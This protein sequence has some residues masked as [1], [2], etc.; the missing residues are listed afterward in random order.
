MHT[1]APKPKAPQQ[2][3]SAESTVSGR[4]HLRHSPDARSTL[5]SQR[6]IEN[7]ATRRALQADAEAPGAE[8]TGTA[9]HRLGHN[10]GEIPVHAPTAKAIQTKPVIDGP[11]D[12][13]EQEADRVSEQI[14]RTPEPRVQRKCARG[15]A[16]GSEGECEACGKKHQS[17]Q[18]VSVD[19]AGPVAGGFAPPVV[20]DVLRSPAR[21]LAPQTRALMEAHFGHDF[22]Q[23]RI[24]AD[25]GASHAADAVQAQ[26]FTYGSDIVFGSG[27]FAPS[28]QAGLRLLAHELTHV[29]QQGAAPPKAATRS[30]AE[31]A[32]EGATGA[33]APRPT[34]VSEPG[35]LQRRPKDGKDSPERETC[36]PVERGER[37]EAAG[38]QLRLVERIPREEWLIYGFPI[39][40]SEISVAEAGR[41]ISEIA[42]TLQQNHLIYMTSWDPLEVLGFSDCLAG[43]KVDNHAIR[44]LRAAKFCAGVKDYYD[45]GNADLIQPSGPSPLIQSC[46]PAPMAQYVGPNATRVERAQ[47][48]SILIRRVAPAKVQV[49]AAEKVE[50]VE[51]DESYPY[52]PK[53]GPS[54]DNCSIYRGAQ[55]RKLLGEGYT[56]NAHCSCMVTPD[57]P[58][59]NCVRKCLQEKM[60]ALLISEYAGRMPDDP[61]MDIHTAC[62]IIW[63][64][65]R[66]CY[67][68]CGCASEFIDYLP[69]RLVCDKSLP[70]AVDSAAIN[71]TNRCMPA[72]KGDKYLPV[73]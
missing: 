55:S 16:H 66:E 5:H 46:G 22:S 50:F 44:Q 58:H 29:V 20:D 64:D 13:S 62:P 72:T 35:R 6:A 48:R 59:N 73:D 27:K 63:R 40:G 18:R 33:E 25:T 56:K 43:P 37:E 68:D 7:Q 9:T 23:V 17:L 24:H 2:T 67:H 14:V 61:L 41:F 19:A 15:G 26:A 42:T 34:R 3:T 21:P 65:H 12:G 45:G 11:G 69:F 60:V 49:D 52:D 71:L 39:G 38:A 53:Y 70:C 28:T 36:P 1:F 32:G 51:G 47:N 30:P 57:E 31:A 10:F 54:A 4:D 8:L